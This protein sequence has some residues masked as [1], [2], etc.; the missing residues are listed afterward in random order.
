MGKST[1]AAM[2]EHMG[3]AIHDSDK[4]VHHA[5]SPKGEAFEE[6]AVTFPACWDKKKHI[7]KRNKLADIIFSD[8]DKKRELE[9][10]LHPIVQ[11]SQSKFA[12]SQKNLGKKF[13]VFDI[14]LLFETNA[15]RRVNYTIC[16]Y[17]P[18]HIQKRRVLSRPNMNIEKFYKILNAQMPSRQK[19]ALSDF[20]VPTGL[21]L[22]Y[23]YQKL[24]EIIATLS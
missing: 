16:V 5:L 3:C 20:T 4:I 14:P 24:E 19:C 23:T 2:L 7:I 18:E 6:V 17:A 1:A 9:N 13:I 11:R 15:Q 10:I 12:W 22:A 8:Q 21:G